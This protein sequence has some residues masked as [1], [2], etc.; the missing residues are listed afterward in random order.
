MKP[1]PV[2]DHDAALVQRVA[3]ASMSSMMSGS[4]TTVR[5]SSTSLMH[6]RRVEE[7]HADHP[8][9]ASGAHRDLGDRQRRRVRRE[10]ASGRQTLSSSPNTRRL[11]LEVLGN[12][13]DDEIGVG[14][15]GHRR[16]GGDPGEQRVGVLLGEL[17][18]PTAR[19]VEC[20]RCARPRATASSSTSTA[21]TCRPLRANTSTMPAPIVPRPTTPT[22]R[23]SRAIPRSSQTTSATRC[24]AA[25]EPTVRGEKSA[26]A[27]L[28][29]A[30]RRL[31][32]RP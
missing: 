20:S 9:R 25:N 11:E 22:V 19:A 26:P 23:N 18:A 8:A 5:T 28:A 13:L 32:C 15:V 1:G 27:G 24:D 30:R 29:A 3:N 21:I 16:G 14:E 7:V 2:A 17:A 10:D 4:V 31:G 6:R 12:G